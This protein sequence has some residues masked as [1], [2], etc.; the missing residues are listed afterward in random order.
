MEGSEP[1]FRGMSFILQREEDK[2]SDCPGKPSPISGICDEWG[3][4]IAPTGESD[5]GR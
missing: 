3:V 5:W 4:E 1:S 2:S